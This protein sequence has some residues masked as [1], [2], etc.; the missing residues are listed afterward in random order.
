MTHRLRHL[1]RNLVHRE[2]VE[3]DLDD[4][5]RTVFELLVDEKVNG[6]LSP[7]EARRMATLQLGRADSI[8]THVR[9]IRAGAFWDAFQQ[10]VRYGVRLL[11]HN[12]LFT[13]TATL[14]LAICIA[15]NTTIFS[16]ANRLLL[17][18]AAG[19]EE[20][21]RLVDIAPT[22]SD[23]RFFEPMVPYRMY[24]EIRGR[25]TTLEGVYGYELDIRA[26][27]LRGP[28]GAERIFST[29][30]TSNYFSVL[31]IRPVV[32]RLF[33]P[34]DGEESG[35]SDAVVLSHGFWTRRFNADPAIVGQTLRINGQ[36]V[37]VVG[38]TPE[39]FQGLSLVVADVW[40]PT[41][42]TAA[43]V[44]QEAS[45]LV[46]GGRLK[47][48]VSISQ[49]AAELDAIGRALQ[50]DMPSR[51]VVGPLMDN[52][53]AGG[54]LR[55]VAASP[56]PPIV[57]TLISGF[58]AL[59][60]AIVSLVLVIACANVAGVL[61]ARATTRRREIAV[62]LA[63]GAGRLRLIRQLLTETVLLFVLGGAAGLALAR[64]MTS[65]IVLTLP[66]LPVP[67]DTSLPL[68]G[69]VI[70]FTAIVS[71]VAAILCGLVPALQASK[72]DVVSALKADA[73]GPSD[74]LRLR[75]LFVVAQI[76]F[77]IL[78]VVS[79]GLLVRALQRSASI[80]LGFD[81][82]G[83]E[84][85]TLDLS[86][87]GYANKTGPLVVQDILER[88]R[89]IPGVS[90][91]SAATTLPMGGQRRECCGVEVPGV[92]P[93][94]GQPFF[95]PA[96]A[97]V[98]PGYFG[99]MRI[100]LVTGRD[101][102]SADRPGTEQVA[103]IS[104]TAAR[105]FWPGQNAIGK[106]LVWQRMPSL[107]A[108]PPGGAMPRPTISPVRLSVIGVA[109]DLSGGRTP[110]PLVYVPFQQHYE[111][112][113]AIIARSTNGQRLTGEIREVV[114]A[115]NPNLPIV[116]ASRLTDQT[117]PVL[118]QLRVAAGVSAGVGLVAMLLA[119]IGIY[120][121]TAYSVARRTREIGIRVAMG[122]Q[123]ADVVG[124]VLRQGMSLV[125][126]GSAV[127][128]LLAAAASR[129]LVRLLFGIPPLDPVTFGGAAM[130]FAAIGLAACYVPTRRAT[131]I[132]AT[133]ALRYE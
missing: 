32:G 53:G 102:T 31:R 26:M 126:I 107:F 115:A 111:S 94:D 78:L 59:L 69:R 133:E 66:A 118:L 93:P 23:G 71:L 13:L 2:R 44:S 43:L 28:A 17:R 58:L 56:L 47:T 63:I 119:A 80:S 9:D 48:G 22:R 72:A 65:L 84:V 76:A 98:E 5:V 33:G 125:V 35:G 57:R 34:Q 114:A 40:L 124:M 86:L 15:A 68:D 52:R 39:G 8:K 109:G 30:V 54:S 49:A 46:V 81:A 61:L 101:F 6:G 79:A 87:A 51:E 24:A 14:S 132:N 29:F 91:A 128:L 67:V 21:D 27:S 92:T 37:T 16:L 10:D 88:L 113:I 25:A 103:I 42:R 70:A 55:L 19:V 4:E 50:R 127:G 82:H 74:R 96:W 77:S 85:A 41:S 117:S 75:S 120:G 100:R 7:A 83:V 3:R 60:L 1:W 129:L 12:P 105:L 104:E 122:A 116:A 130:L 131:R 64:V 38:V 108:R 106:H 99:T 97:V 62:R 20:P 73:Q 11:W 95:Q 90:G 45:R 110:T 121:V 112:H 36:P 123:R 89:A 18:E